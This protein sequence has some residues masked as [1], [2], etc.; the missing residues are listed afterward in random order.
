MLLLYAKNKRILRR[1]K[2][3]YTPCT[4]TNFVTFI[5]ADSINWTEQNLE[6]AKKT[7]H[8]RLNILDKP[9]ALNAKDEHCQEMTDLRMELGT[10]ANTIK[11]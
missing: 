5:S 8:N 10:I 1:V 7:F 4:H 11:V 9:I 3:G 6:N 2:P